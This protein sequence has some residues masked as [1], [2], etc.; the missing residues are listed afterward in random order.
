MTTNIK[1]EYKSKSNLE[2]AVQCAN[3][4]LSFTMRLTI[5]SIYTPRPN[6]R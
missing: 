3:S 5:E 6:D 4:V 1:G 2:P